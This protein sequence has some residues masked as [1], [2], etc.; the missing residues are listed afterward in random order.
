MKNLAITLTII[1]LAT[2]VVASA[3]ITDSDIWVLN[4]IISIFSESTKKSQQ[5]IDFLKNKL[6]LMENSC[7][8]GGSS[9]SPVVTPLVLRP[10]ECILFRNVTG[11]N[12]ERR[13]YPSVRERKTFQLPEDGEK[14]NKYKENV[15]NAIEI[16]WSWENRHA[17]LDCTDG[18][19]FLPEQRSEGIISSPYLRVFP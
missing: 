9:P 17:G 14:L 19:F 2:P 5:E 3:H 12:P 11:T 16:G 18:Y 7:V 4:S 8:Q 15:R 6:A 13:Y 10:I 1:L